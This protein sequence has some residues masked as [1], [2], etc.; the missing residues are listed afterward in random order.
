MIQFMEQARIYGCQHSDE[1]NEKRLP[2]AEFKLVHEIYNQH[3]KII[4]IEVTEPVRKSVL[5][6]IESLWCRR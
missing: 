5:Q 1:V 3:I 2:D 4:E 6:Y